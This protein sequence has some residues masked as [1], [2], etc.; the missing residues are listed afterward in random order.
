ML[1][2]IRSAA[3]PAFI[4][5]RA[6]ASTPYAAKTISETVNEVAGNVNKAAGDV[7]KKGKSFSTISPFP[8]WE[9]ADRLNVAWC[10]YRAWRV[11]E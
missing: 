10:R 3:A 4:A 2:A 8:S 7:L 5:R 6:F 11:G 9:V 1:A